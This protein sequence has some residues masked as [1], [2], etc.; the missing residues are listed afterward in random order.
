MQPCHAGSLVVYADVDDY[1]GKFDDKDCLVVAGVRFAKCVY[2]VET[3]KL[4]KPEQMVA[5]VS[6]DVYGNTKDSNN[7]PFHRVDLILERVDYLAAL[8]DR[9]IKDCRERNYANY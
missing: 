1:Y 9:R 7:S 8:L 2:V 4:Y 5:F 3:S 6:F